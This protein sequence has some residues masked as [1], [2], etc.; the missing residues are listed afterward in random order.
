VLFRNFLLPFTEGFFMRQV[1]GDTKTLGA[2]IGFLKNWYRSKPFLIGIFG[3]YFSSKKLR[4]LCLF[5][6]WQKTP[7]RFFSQYKNPNLG[8]KQ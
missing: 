1:F 5:L 3:C 8:R 7:A 6:I 2:C 4:L